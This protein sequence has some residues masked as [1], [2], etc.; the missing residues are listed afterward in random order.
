MR[1][2]WRAL[3]EGPDGCSMEL[4]NFEIATREDYIG[5]K[6]VR[7]GPLRTFLSTDLLVTRES[8]RMLALL[9]GFPFLLERGN[10]K[11]P[12][13]FTTAEERNEWQSIKRS[14]TLLWYTAGGDWS[15]GWPNRGGS[16]SYICGC[17]EMAW[18]C[19]FSPPCVFF[20]FK[21]FN[22]VAG[23]HLWGR[24]FCRGGVWVFP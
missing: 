22:E 9:L 2:N 18:I 6:K 24:P 20:L 7:A 1:Q 21:K 10:L 17:S 12:R 3:Y 15:P 16:I 23:R 19:V 13:Q 4:T 14:T 5:L 11:T 8:R